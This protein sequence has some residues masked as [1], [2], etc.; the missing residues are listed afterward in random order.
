WFPQLALIPTD[1]LEKSSTIY[2]KGDLVVML[3]MEGE[4]VETTPLLKLE[5]RCSPR[6]G[7]RL[8]GFVNKNE[9]LADNPIY[10]PVTNGCPHKELTALVIHDSFGRLLRPFL[11]EYFREVTYMR[12]SDF[13][14]MRDYILEKRPD[15]VIEQRIARTMKAFLRSDPAA[16][17]QWLGDRFN[18]M[19]GVALQITGQHRGGVVESANQLQTQSSSQGLILESSGSDP[20]L[21]FSMEQSL[22]T[23]ALVRLEL[24]SP[25]PTVL[26][27]FYLAEGMESFS[28]G[29]SV[30]I[31]VK[32][33]KNDLLLSLP[34]KNISTRVRL[35]PGKTAGRYVL[36]SMEVRYPVESSRAEQ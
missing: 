16:R 29:D 32:E 6:Y 21:V 14:G 36:H 5:K 26:E 30:R 17:N 15:V 9:K 33:G 20:F 27:L 22:S 18:K 35:D 12:F 28:S 24:T 25:A 4:L 13:D 2:K 7:Q 19:R 3:N 10:L 11:S 34:G 23:G 8:E 31:K 1:G